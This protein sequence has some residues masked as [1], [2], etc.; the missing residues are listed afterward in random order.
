MMVNFC[1]CVGCSNRWPRN[2]DKSFYRL[3]TVITHQGEQTRALSERR[4]RLWLAAIKRQD[5]KAKNFQHIRVCSDHFICGKSSALY[6]STSPDWVPSL[7]MGHNK[8]GCIN[9]SDRY[10]RANSRKRR[11]HE[12]EFRETGTAVQTDMTSSDIVQLQQEVNRL[13]RK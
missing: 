3:P 13:K 10:E 7:N 6:D 2:K 1:A 4:Q 8:A 5:I 12:V 9:D 11:A